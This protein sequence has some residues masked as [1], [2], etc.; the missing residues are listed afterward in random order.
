MPLWNVAKVRASELH[1]KKTPKLTQAPAMTDDFYMSLSIMNIFAGEFSYKRLQ[2]RDFLGGPPRKL[3]IFLTIASNASVMF[4]FS[5]ALVSN[6]AQC[7]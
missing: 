2:C 5:L 3:Q 6:A 4:T 7:S 1:Y